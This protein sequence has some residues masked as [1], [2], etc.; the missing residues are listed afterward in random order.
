MGPDKICA[1]LS[2]PNNE[3]N[4]AGSTYSQTLCALLFLYKEILRIELPWIE[5]ISRPNGPPKRPVIRMQTGV[6]FILEQM[7]GVSQLLA[8]IL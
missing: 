8:G 1:F 5:G 7:S 2:L 6:K 3:R 4:I